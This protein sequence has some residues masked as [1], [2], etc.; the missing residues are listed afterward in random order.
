MSEIDLAQ[1]QVRVRTTDQSQDRRQQILDGVRTALERRIVWVEEQARRLESDV[2]LDPNSIHG[3]RRDA[4]HRSQ[5]VRQAPVR[6]EQVGNRS[7]GLAALARVHAD[8]W[9]LTA[10]LGLHQDPDKLLCWNPAIRSA[11]R[12][13]IHAGGV[14]EIVRVQAELSECGQEVEHLEATHRRRLGVSYAHR[15][16]V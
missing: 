15:G 11:E 8:Q 16:L 3:E 7:P 13:P 10:A 9:I 2:E 6:H 1:L 5:T 14:A 4:R 12:L